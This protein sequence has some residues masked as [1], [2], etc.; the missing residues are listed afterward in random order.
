MAAL[1]HGLGQCVGNPGANSDNRR[2]FDAELHGDGVGNLEADTTDI[3]RQPVG[4]SVMI[5]MA[6]P[7]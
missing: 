5:W 6:S 3:T 4:F 2:L 7:P 1:V